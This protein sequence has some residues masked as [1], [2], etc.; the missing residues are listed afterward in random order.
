MTSLYPI[1][2]NE[3]IENENINE[4]DDNESVPIFIKN[5]YYSD[6]MCNYCNYINLNDI[7]SFYN[8]IN[9]TNF[10]VG[11]SHDYKLYKLDKN[12][13]A[14]LLPFDIVH[15]F[16]ISSDEKYIATIYNKII[17]IYNLTTFKLIKQLTCNFNYCLK[18]MFSSDNKNI[19]INDNNNVF[20]SNI[21]DN[22][23]QQIGIK[24]CSTFSVNNEYII[25]GEINKLNIYN[26][27][28]YELIKTINL[29]INENEYIAQI[30]CIDN[31]IV[32]ALSNGIIS[33]IND[34]MN[35][36]MNVISYNIQ[37]SYI[38]YMSVSE[39]KKYIISLDNNNSVSVFDLDKNEHMFIINS[40][41]ASSAT[42]SND[43][44]IVGAGWNSSIYSLKY[45]Y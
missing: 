9:T 2:E 34:Y 36:I 10:Y 39:N 27:K 1:I 17:K 8:I 31:K 26:I 14:T 44:E 22:S 13:E 30:L 45:P 11:H 23:V 12:F 4:Y 16:C 18:I 19:I 37:C 42:I 28:N 5:S 20:I 33:I 38:K 40:F 3:Y 21:Y 29:E 25:I 24:N 35:N 32:I 41:P 43:L 15:N 7:K 6:F